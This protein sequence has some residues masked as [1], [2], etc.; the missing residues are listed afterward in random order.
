MSVSCLIASEAPFCKFSLV[1]STFGTYL[2]GLTDGV[3]QS[4]PPLLLEP[5]EPDEEPPLLPLSVQEGQVHSFADTE[6]KAEE[7]AN[8]TAGRATRA[9]EVNRMVL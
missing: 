6:L 1:A 5:E 3:H 2:M 7:E 8:S 4:P 9:L